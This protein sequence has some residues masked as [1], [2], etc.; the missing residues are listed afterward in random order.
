MRFLKRKSR[1]DVGVWIYSSRHS[2]SCLIKYSL[3]MRHFKMSEFSGNVVW[4]Y[5]VYSKLKSF[6]AQLQ[7]NL[8][9]YMVILTRSL[10]IQS[11]K[12]SDQFSKIIKMWFWTNEVH[13]NK[14]R[15]GGPRECSVIFSSI[16]IA[17]LGETNLIL[18]SEFTTYSRGSSESPRRA[19]LLRYCLNNVKWKERIEI[20]T[21]NP[22]SRSFIFI[23]TE[24]DTKNTSFT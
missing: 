15:Q 9:M 13:S 11:L 24:K 6:L 19:L 12:Q 17:W 4:I 7:M 20:G 8:S 10:S 2:W 18:E 1:T 16:L 3:E 23:L 5:F 21:Q 14:Y 22:L